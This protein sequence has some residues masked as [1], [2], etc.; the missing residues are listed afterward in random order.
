MSKSVS[1]KPKRKILTL[2]EK[3]EIV[4]RKECGEKT[5]SL[6]REFKV[7]MS[8]ICTILSNRES[9]KRSC[10]SKGIK[11]ICNA[12]QR[13]PT[14]DQ[15]EMLLLKWIEVMQNDG[16]PLSQAI[17][18]EKA[19]RLFTQLQ[20]NSE[21][22]NQ[23]SES[24]QQT[25]FAAFKASPNWFK[26][27]K[28]RTGIR[29]ALSHGES[30]SADVAAA[31]DFIL[32][33]REIIQSE[34]ED[35]DN[36][37]E[38]WRDDSGAT[39]SPAVGQHLNLQMDEDE[40]NFHEGWRDDSGATGSP[41]VGQHLNL[42][43]DEDE[44][45]FHE[46]WRDDSGATGSPAVGQHLNSETTREILALGEYLNL[47]MDEDDISDVKLKIFDEFFKNLVCSNVTAVVTLTFDIS[48]S[49]YIVLIQPNLAALNFFQGI[50]VRFSEDFV[51]WKNFW[52][53]QEP[54]R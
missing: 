28:N 38:G 11:R 35:E 47:E 13:N 51:L 2:L 17:I 48:K 5:S 34:D 21:N 12:T 45:N 46:G 23:A 54:H 16:H 53:L 32:K 41:A 36:F 22:E 27:F 4:R 6:A 49:K 40:D 50:R 24:S 29:V 31:D 3:K 26:A 8:S 33:F 42:Q 1:E 39:G 7:A 52:L 30:A 44:D 37:H 25:S 18:C 20:E 19:R 15:M 10:P 9:I 14:C 43:M